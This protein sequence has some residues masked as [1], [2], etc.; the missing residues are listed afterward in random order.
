MDT[1]SILEPKSL[2]DQLEENHKD[3]NQNGE[4]FSGYGIMGLTFS[5][6]H[7]LGL[8]RFPASSIGPGYTSVWY[9]NPQGRWTFFQSITPEHACSRYFGKAISKTLIRDIDIKWNGSQ[10]FTVT[11][12]EDVDLNWQISLAQTRATR[13]INSLNTFIPNFLWHNKLFLNGMSSIAGRILHTGHIRLT[14]KAP[15][16]QW[17]KANPKKLW[18]IDSSSA[19]IKGSFFGNIEPLQ[20]Q[21]RLGD[22]WIPQRGIF[23]IGEASFQPY[24]PSRHKLV[25]SLEQL[26]L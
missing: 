5:S 11:I 15:N 8:R 16:G 17:F 19:S 14:G 18:I 12:G 20:Y 21:A 1:K 9:R 23:A 25:T 7:I 2:V 6:G 24:N 3:F 26:E 22:F 10:C 13:I 4:H